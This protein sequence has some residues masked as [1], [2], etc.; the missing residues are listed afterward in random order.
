MWDHQT[1][2][3]EKEADPLPNGHVE[4]GVASP[5]LRRKRRKRTAEGLNDEGL[6]QG[7]GNGSRRKIGLGLDGETLSWPNH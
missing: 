2:Q 4:E 5:R 7:S 6:N 1:S 3:R